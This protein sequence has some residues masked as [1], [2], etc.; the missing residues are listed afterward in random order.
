MLFLFAVMLMYALPKLDRSHDVAAGAR[1]LIGTIRSLA[2]AASSSKQTYTLYLDLDHR[3][4]WAMTLDGP[5]ERPSS[6]PGLAGRGALPDQVRFVD[7]TTAGQGTVTAGTASIRFLPVGRTE[8]ALIRLGNQADAMLSLEL[9][10]VTGAVRVL[11][12]AVRPDPPDP[13]P[14]RLR[15]IVLP[16]LPAG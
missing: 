3:T 13:V 15:A 14:E 6:D 16:P 12:G 2:L 5:S 7:I 9:N 1:R 8:R 4:Y 11:E 10:P